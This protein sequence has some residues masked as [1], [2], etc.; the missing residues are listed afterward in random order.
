MYIAH[1][2]KENVCDLVFF[3]GAAVLCTEG[4]NLYVNIVCQQPRYYIQV[5]KVYFFL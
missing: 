2:V 1:L 4:A 5:V 3:T